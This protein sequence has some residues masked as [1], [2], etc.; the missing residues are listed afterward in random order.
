MTQITRQHGLQVWTVVS[1]DGGT[2]ASIVPALGAAVSSLLWPAPVAGR[3]LLFQHEWFWDPARAET[4]G[5][6]PILF[7]NCG[8][9]LRDGA[10]G[11]WAYGGREYHLPIHGF[12][13]RRPWVVLD[14][15]RSHELV[16]GL[17]DS[18]ETREGFPFA[19]ELT[20]RFAVAERRFSCEVTVRNRGVEALPCGLGFHPYFRTPP[21]GA[22][23]EDVII[24]APV[25]RRRRYDATYTDFEGDL[26]APGEWTVRDP[27]FSTSLMETE[28]DAVA[29]IRW[30]DGLALRIG[31]RGGDGGFQARHLQMY[32]VPELPFIC[33]EPWAGRPNDLN[34][35]HGPLW[36][37][38]GAAARIAFSIESG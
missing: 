13:M 36:L 19:F 37:A 31:A 3:E 25:A 30:P 20:L 38:G 34:R 11:A 8:R 24:T 22:G 4:R 1:P 15:R 5:G 2:R 28:Q 21:P 17:V 18:R 16:L 9:L 12:A 14:D 27:D 6:I 32:T 10:P 7:P 26:P 23:K 33:V 35:G 29:R